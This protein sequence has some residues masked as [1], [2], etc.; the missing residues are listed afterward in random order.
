MSR[1]LMFSLGIHA[2][3]CRIGAC[4]KGA[5]R[6]TYS[7]D[8]GECAVTHENLPAV[9]QVL[10]GVYMVVGPRMVAT[11]SLGEV[12]WLFW[13][14]AVLFRH[15]GAWQWRGGPSCSARGHCTLRPFVSCAH[16]VDGNGHRL[17]VSS[18]TSPSHQSCLSI[19]HEDIINSSLSR[20]IFLCID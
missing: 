3:L 9:F 5:A 14:G 1:F 19:P 8:A 6:R 4:Q 15:R 2:K 10:Y 11:Y 13:A 16:P 20:P 7:A 18:Y 17:P 12:F